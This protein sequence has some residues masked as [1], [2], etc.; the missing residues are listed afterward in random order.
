MRRLVLH[1]ATC[2]LALATRTRSDARSTIDGH[3][4]GPRGRARRR[5]ATRQRA[6]R[7]S[8]RRQRT[9][10]GVRRPWPLLRARRATHYGSSSRASATPRYRSPRGGT[11]PAKTARTDSGVVIV[12]RWASHLTGDVHAGR[13]RLAP[14]RQEAPSPRPAEISPRGT[15][16]SAPSGVCGVV[17]VRRPGGD[18][19]RSWLYSA[20]LAV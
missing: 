6:T 5:R 14:V 9:R 3:G 11:D 18:S 16:M 1:V 12:E 20:D 4:A 15:Q 2:I 8:T 19:A 13:L 10:R 17:G 7:T